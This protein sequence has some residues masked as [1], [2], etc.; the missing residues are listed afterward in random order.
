M[1]LPTNDYRRT[2]IL[3]PEKITEGLD[4]VVD[5]VA[6]RIRRRQTI[7]SSLFE[8]AQ[9][10]DGLAAELSHL[11]DKRLKDKLTMYKEVLRRRQS[12]W[13]DNRFEALAAIREAS[14]RTIGLTPYRVQLVGALAIFEGYLAE[15]ATG[16]GKTLVAGLA[17]IL[18]GWSRLPCH[19]ITVNDY[20]ARRDAEWLRP[21]FNYCGVTVSSVT[22]QM[23]PAERQ[24]AYDQDVAYVTSKEILA[25][26]LRDRLRI[27]SLHDASRRNLRYLL[28][29]QLATAVHQVM[30][31]I[32]TAIVDEADSVLIDEAVTPLIISTHHENTA[33][34]HAADVANEIALHLEK[35]HDYR[36]NLLY[37]EIELDKPA[38]R[39][40]D[41]LC[42]TLP[43]IWKGPDRRQEL[44]RQAL[45]AKE[46][47]HEGK[48][49][50]LQDNK[51]VIVDEYTG[52]MMPQRTWRQGLHQAIEA[53]HGLKLTN[54]SE[55]LARLSFQRFFRFFHH[56]SGMTGTAKEA[57][58]EFW[59]IYRLPIVTIPQNRPLRRR[60][61]PDCV[62]PTQETKWE[63]VVQEI[64]ELHKEGLPV[65][66]GVRS[67]KAS[68]ILADKLRA[69]NLEFALLNAEKHEEEANIVAQAGQPKRITIATNM[70]GRG[71]DIILG[72][73]VA[74][75]GGLQILLTERHESHRIDRQF[76]G[77]C[78]RQGDPGCAQAF[79]SIDDEL[80][81]RFLPEIVRKN[82]TAAARYR[83]PGS[84]RQIISAI[85]YAQFAAQR[86]AFKQRRQVLKMDTWID[87]SLSF[88]GLGDVM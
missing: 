80:L 51:V 18:H 22:S 25:D 70:A 39:K 53:K 42:E 45:T 41:A 16:E 75:R 67:V 21:L 62:F 6:G 7:R 59:H 82:L 88:S 73:G 68:E 47:F 66:V 24:R 33:L 71:T 52:R 74:E 12:G 61:L 37:R 83:Y 87:D 50:I 81:R 32:H 10:I 76:F 69:V 40:I 26:F 36:V 23:Q 28:N 55:T 8:A 13:E 48:Q 77:R 9:K 54:P 4:S 65:L 15:M 29:P 44:V 64:A 14:S 56:L 31:G 3:R 30:R 58:S 2:A 17:A 46:F 35:G 49:Y 57:A 79:V 43:G 20:L 60:E 85:K 72:K 86:M 19:V 84:Q 11:S 34:K 78:A 63:A 38:L 27:G 5:S 1:V